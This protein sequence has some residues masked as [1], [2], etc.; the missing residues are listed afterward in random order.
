MTSH[1]RWGEAPSM[2]KATNG[3]PSLEGRCPRDYLAREVLGHS[4]SSD[5]P[6]VI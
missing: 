6:K 5:P 2:L 3:P 4:H 1:F